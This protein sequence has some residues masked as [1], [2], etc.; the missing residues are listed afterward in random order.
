[1]AQEL[2]DSVGHSLMALTL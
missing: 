1:M 2:H